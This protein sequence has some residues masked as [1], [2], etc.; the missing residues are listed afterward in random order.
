M[1]SLTFMLCVFSDPGKMFV[2]LF[3][4]AW[5]SFISE[6]EHPICIQ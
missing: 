3:R 2:Y 1:Y 5:S 4:V 6:R